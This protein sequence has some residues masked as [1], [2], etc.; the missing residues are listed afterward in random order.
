VKCDLLELSFVA[1]RLLEAEIAKE[2]DLLE[3]ML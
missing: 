3:G 2:L 1:L